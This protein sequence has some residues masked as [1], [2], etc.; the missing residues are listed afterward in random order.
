MAGFKQIICALLLFGASGVAVAQ[1]NTNSPYTRYGYGDLSNREFANS[2]AMG[3]IA[4]GLRSNSHI[5]PLNPASYTAIDSLTF[6]FEGGV[7]LQ[8]DN[9]GDGDLKMNVKNSSL[10]YI[11]MQFRAHK[12]VGITLGMLPFS[13]VGY[14]VYTTYSSTST[15]PAYTKQMAGDGGLHQA[16]G[17]IGISPVKNLSVGANFS[18]MW[19]DISRSLSMVYPSYTSSSGSTTTPSYIEATSVTMRG[20][21]MDFG[22]QYTQKL[23]KK[24]SVTVGAVYAPKMTLNSDAT[25]STSA[26]V[27]TSK[28]TIATFG[29]PQSYGVGLTYNF[30]NRLTVGFDYSFE[31]WSKVTYFNNANAFCDR[32]KYSFGAEFT[33]SHYTRNYLKIV[34][35]R[36]GAYYTDSYYKTEGGQRAAREYGV[37]CGLGL[38]LPRTRSLLNLTGQYV[39][40][41]GLETSMINEN[42]F[43]LTIGVTFNERWFFK[44]KVD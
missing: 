20:F 27:T 28:D 41:K 30:D 4:Y 32:S 29:L 31:E 38:P 18:L 3:G 14:N 17:G 1:N 26:S 8:N 39:H 19:G 44:R 5:N 12:G 34:K 7:S 37:S 40:V 36:V 9:I 2:K 21:K 42:I 13:S 10:D 22:L 16:F 43:R 15:S 35:Y 23:S 25:A 11:A 33:P 24:N 6:L